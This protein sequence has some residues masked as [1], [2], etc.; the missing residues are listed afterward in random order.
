MITSSVHSLF[1]LHLIFRLW[2]LI[3]VHL[4]CATTG[5]RWPTSELIFFPTHCTL[6]TPQGSLHK[7]M[8]RRHQSTRMLSGE[9][10]LVVI[11]TQVLSYNF[12]REAFNGS[13]LSALSCIDE[14]LLCNKQ[15]QSTELKT[16]RSLLMHLQWRM[17]LFHAFRVPS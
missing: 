10:K 17:A 3:N 11:V 1:Q 4:S 12:Q 15:L 9:L 2:L 14:L 6:P 16:K 5:Q 8:A 7:A 13:L